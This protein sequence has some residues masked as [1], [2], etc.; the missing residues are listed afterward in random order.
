MQGWP[1]MATANEVLLLTA[2]PSPAAAASGVVEVQGQPAEAADED[3]EM[4]GEYVVSWL[5]LQLVA[6]AAP[7]ALHGTP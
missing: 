4:R 3:K 5:L 6:D 1:M 7:S 2:P